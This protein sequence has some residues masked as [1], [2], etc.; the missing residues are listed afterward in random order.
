VRSGSIEARDRGRRIAAGGIGRTSDS[1]RRSWI[2]RR[3]GRD[4]GRGGDGEIFGR[5]LKRNER[6]SGG[7]GYTAST[8]RQ[9][10]RIIDFLV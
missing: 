1:I 6:R 7:G 8:A 4:G 3:K 5:K 2:R 10:R 9:G